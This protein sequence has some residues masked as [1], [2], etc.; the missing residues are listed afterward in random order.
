MDRSRTQ[1]VVVALPTANDYVRKI[2]SEKEP[3]LTLLYLGK[4]GFDQSQ[5]TR[6]QEYVDHASTLLPQFTLDVERRG[7]L[8]EKDAD[9]LF[10]S[11]RWSKEIVR[12]RESLLQNPLVSTA[13]NSAEQ[14]EGWTPHLTVGYPGTPAKKDPNG[15]DGDVTFVKFDR[16]AL[17]IGDS[18]GPTF[19]LKPYSYEEVEM[20]ALAHYGV[21]GM[22]WGVRR[23]DAQ[24]A[25]SPAPRAPRMSED[26][27][28][29][30]NLQDKIES[31]GTTA[32]SNQEMRQY[33]E[34]VDLERRYSQTISSPSS[35]NQL[36]RGHD[37]VKKILAYGETYDKARKFVE[38]PTG[39]MIKNGV[40]TAASAGL[41]YVTGGTSAAAVA[42]VSTIIRRFGS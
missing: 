1:L 28:K 37:Q 33:L 2:S 18:E 7:L 24:L 20:S 39:Q 6:L 31:R 38:S 22:K 35:K 4:P 30:Y 32:L 16:I 5:L 17:W 8:G 12:F 13:Y 3:H 27:R 14:F 15:Y 41:A 40:T 29:A 11:K 36:D 34:R 19:D 21:K 10:F 26:A 25:S 9:V 42:G 23:T